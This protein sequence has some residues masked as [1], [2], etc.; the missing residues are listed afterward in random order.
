MK[1][2]KFTIEVHTNGRFSKQICKSIDLVIPDT[3]RV[4]QFPFHEVDEVAFLI[5][6]GKLA[7]Y[8]HQ[9]IC[10]L[11]FKNSVYRKNSFPKREQPKTLIR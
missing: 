8:M 7:A 9:N 1:R 5:L 3:Y 11:C 2:I 6:E 10:I 4:H